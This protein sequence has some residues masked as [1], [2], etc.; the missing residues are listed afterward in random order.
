MTTTTWMMTSDAADLLNDAAS[1]L[2]SDWM[3]LFQ[4]K[5]TQQL[6]E[7]KNALVSP[8]PSPSQCQYVGFSV[9]DISKYKHLHFVAVMNY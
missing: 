7:R 1:S 6:L 9:Q 8:P 4:S 3:T 5:D 2:Q